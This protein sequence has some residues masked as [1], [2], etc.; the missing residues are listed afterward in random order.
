VSQVVEGVPGGEQRVP[1][2]PASQSYVNADEVVADPDIAHDKFSLHPDDP[3]NFLKLCCALRIF[4]RRRP[5]DA[6]IDRADRLL[7]E[8]CMELITVSYSA[9]V[10]HRVAN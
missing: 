5:T 8:Y 4:V 7:R 6:D 10:F 1:P 9:F 3:K 2:P